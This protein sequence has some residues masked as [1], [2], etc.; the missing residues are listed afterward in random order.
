MPLF[1]RK[2]HEARK[3]RMMKYYRKD[4]ST[5]ELTEAQDRETRELD[6]ELNWDEPERLK[7]IGKACI[8]SKYFDLAEWVFERVMQLDEDDDE[9]IIEFTSALLNQERWDEAEEMISG[10]LMTNPESS[11][12]HQFLAAIHEKKGKHDE[13]MEEMNMAL[14]CDPNN[15][16][17]LW[18][19]YWKIH[20]VSG[21]NGA[22][23]KMQELAVEF[24]QAW[25]P[26]N[27]MARHYEDLNPD[28]AMEHYETAL[29]KDDADP[30]LISFSAF[31][32]K[33]G[34]HKEMIRVIEESRKKKEVDFRVLFNLGEAYLEEGK[35]DKAHE[36]SIE[37]QAVVPPPYLGRLKDFIH[38]VHSANRG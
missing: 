35:V 13:A 1:R 21:D 25:G 5:I 31:M 28:V 9:I 15:E 26:V 30:I 36:L 10:F 8:Q 27:I 33:T 24:P 19:I 17:V 18:M 20:K 34:N 4:G 11:V 16:N 22:L 6:A 23:K 2:K 7:E 12:G 29:R 14:E 37:L 32:G 3:V 38:R